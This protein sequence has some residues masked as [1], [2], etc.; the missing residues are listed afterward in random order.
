[1]TTANERNILTMVIWTVLDSCALNRRTPLLGLAT[2]HHAEKFINSLSRNSAQALVAPAEL[3]RWPNVLM[4]IVK[5]AGTSLRKKNGPRER[6]EREGPEGVGG[7]G[8]GHKPQNQQGQCLVASHC[9]Q[10]QVAR[11]RYF[12]NSI[13]NTSR[14]LMETKSCGKWVQ[15]SA[16]QTRIKLTQ[17]RVGKGHLVRH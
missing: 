2:S 4:M 1:M 5:W 9:E 11:L 6:R 15:A 3:E 7:G 8:G 13:S 14:A 17:F 16:H 12:G 10:V